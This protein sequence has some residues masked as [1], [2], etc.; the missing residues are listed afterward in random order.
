MGS[1]DLLPFW[2]SSSAKAVCK[3]VLVQFLVFLA[4]SRLLARVF[5]FVCSLSCHI[6]IEGEGCQLFKASSKGFHKLN[7]L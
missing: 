6:L 1:L 2:L 7:L 5:Q 3:A 4:V